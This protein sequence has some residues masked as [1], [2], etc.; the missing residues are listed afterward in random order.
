MRGGMRR[1]HWNVH[2]PRMF[3]RVKGL[4]DGELRTWDLSRDLVAVRLFVGKGDEET[5]EKGWW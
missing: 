3:E 5:D 4:S 1:H 2:E